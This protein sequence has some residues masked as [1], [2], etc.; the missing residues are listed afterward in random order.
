MTA[1]ISVLIVDDHAIARLGLRAMLE[2]DPQVQVVGEASSGAEALERTEQLQPSVVLMDIKMPNM[3]GLETTRQLK[4]Q[5]PAT[6]VIILTNHDDEAMVVEAVRVGAGGYLLKDASRD[7]LVNTIGAVASGG[8]LI[9]AP[10]LRKALGNH[11]HPGATTE[12]RRSAS[13]ANPGDGL[14]ERDLVII[15]KMAEGQTNKEIADALGLAEVTVKKQVQGIIA[16]LR[17]SDR[18]HATITALRLGIIT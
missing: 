18:T 14:G 8:I 1:P 9:E 4:N 11:A 3:D 13:S 2:S 6:S 17:A 10:L 15:A 7:L 16:K 5:Y 12:R